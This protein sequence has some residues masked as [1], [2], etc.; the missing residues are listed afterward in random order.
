MA[1]IGIA[2]ILKACLAGWPLHEDAIAFIG[3]YI[4]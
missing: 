2:K 3:A 1:F 4:G